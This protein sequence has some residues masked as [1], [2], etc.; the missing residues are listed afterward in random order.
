M[1][2][3]PS[4]TQNLVG[5]IRS[6]LERHI[7]EL[8]NHSRLGSQKSDTTVQARSMLISLPFLLATVGKD[9]S[10]LEDDRAMLLQELSDMKAVVGEL[11][12]LASDLRERLQRVLEVNAAFENEN[13]EL[14]RKCEESTRQGARLA[15]MVDLLQSRDGAP[16]QHSELPAAPPSWQLSARTDAVISDG[17]S[18]KAKSVAVQTEDAEQ[19]KDSSLQRQIEGL[20]AQVTSL[21]RSL[22]IARAETEYVAER[23]KTLDGMVSSL[24]E[25]IGTQ[26]LAMNQMATSSDK[27]SQERRAFLR[28]ADIT[29]RAAADSAA[30]TMKR[31]RQENVPQRTHTKEIPVGGPNLAAPENNDGKQY[32][33]DSETDIAPLG[34]YTDEEFENQSDGVEP[35]EDWEEGDNLLAPDVH[36]MQLESPRGALPPRS[37]TFRGATY[38]TTT[39]VRFHSPQT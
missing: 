7:E 21:Q 27:R 19:R 6:V 2:M 28:A 4:H 33:D 15:S 36:A 10:Q 20:Q 39:G 23:N 32:T 5:V 12:K 26:Q 13:K 24:N 14:T 16:T 18:D 31:A 35:A 1:A 22:D 9:V 8:G 11:T 3:P 37:P 34:D 38:K 17:V 30:P 29:H 25:I